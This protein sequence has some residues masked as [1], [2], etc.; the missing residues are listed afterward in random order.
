MI[1]IHNF[2]ERQMSG[3]MG[4]TTSPLD[5]LRFPL[6]QQLLEIMRT[7]GDSQDHYKGND[8]IIL[9]R[10]FLSLNYTTVS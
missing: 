2:K 1:L 3:G 9:L 4:S 6:E 8:L 5:T 7:T 10:D